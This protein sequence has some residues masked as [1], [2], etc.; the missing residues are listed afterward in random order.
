MSPVAGR[1]RRT[2]RPRTSQGRSQVTRSPRAASTV[3]RRS[4]ASRSHRPRRTRSQHRPEGARRR[5]ATAAVAC[6]GTPPAHGQ[7]R[8]PPVDQESSLPL[9]IAYLHAEPV[10]ITTRVARPLQPLTS[11]DYH[12]APPGTLTWESDPSETQRRARPGS[13]GTTGAS[14]HRGRRGGV[15]P[16]AGSRRPLACAVLDGSRRVARSDMVPR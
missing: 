1:V 14:C 10:V 6:A 5:R 4:R 11:R 7:R 3:W 15:H 9:I 16:D 13:R 8:G 12:V 2:S